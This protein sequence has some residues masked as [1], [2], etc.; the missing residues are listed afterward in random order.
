VSITLQQLLGCMPNAADRA[1]I[2]LEPLNAALIEF[3]VDSLQERAAFLAELAHESADLRFMR[4]IWGP[5]PQQL[6][7]EGREELGNTQPGDGKRFIGRGGLMTTGRTNTLRCLAAL[8]RAETDLDYIETPIGGMRSAGWMWKD[9]GCD[10]PASQGNFA[11]CTKRLNGGYTNLDDRI[12]RY[13][14]SR[15]SLGL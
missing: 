5:T 15:K 3:H 7:Y 8:G 4:E 2:F 9:L 10:V 6:T 11:T 13:V 1:Q 12:K 14:L